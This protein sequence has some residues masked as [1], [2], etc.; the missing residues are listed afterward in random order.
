MTTALNSRY[1]NTQ[2]PQTP[3]AL[4][5]SE[6]GYLA[7][8]TGSTITIYSVGTQ[9]GGLHRSSDYL[10]AAHIAQVGLID[11]TYETS[12]FCSNALELGEEIGARLT[13]VSALTKDVPVPNLKSRREEFYD[14]INHFVDMA[15]SRPNMKGECHL[16]TV[17]SRG[18]V[19]IHT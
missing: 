16:A 11:S 14:P 15:W 1:L 6:D 2:I 5:Y 17:S 18:L 7:A 8:N 10:T 4:E 12:L 19:Q 13:H 3:N 9:H